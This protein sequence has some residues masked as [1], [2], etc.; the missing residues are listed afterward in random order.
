MKKPA[1]IIFLIIVNFLLYLSLNGQSFNI[2]NYTNTSSTTGFL[3]CDSLLL[4]STEGG[5]LKYNLNNDELIVQYTTSEGISDVFCTSIAGEYD[6]LWITTN[7]GITRETPGVA[8]IYTIKDGIGSKEVKRVIKAS[9][10]TIWAA[11]VNGVSRFSSGQWTNYTMQDGLTDNYARDITEHPDGSIW[12]ATD[13]GGISIYREGSWQPYSLND[14]LPIS[15]VY[16]IAVDTSGTV[17]AGTRLGLSRVNDS[18]VTNY[19]T[20][21]GLLDDWITSLSVDTN[22]NIW[23]GTWYGLSMYNHTIFKN[24]DIDHVAKN[25]KITSLYSDNQGIM[26]VGT[27]NGFL[28]YQDS[29][30]QYHRVFHQIPSNKVEEIAHQDKYVWAATRKG[31]AGFSNNKWS[32]Y[33]FSLSG[34]TGFKSVHT[35]K[36]N[37]VWFGCDY[38]YESDT[39]ILAFDGVSW[40]M[41]TWSSSNAVWDIESGSNGK[42]WFGTS[43]LIYYYTGFSLIY[44]FDFTNAPVKDIE[45]DSHGRMWMAND[46]LDLYSNHSLTNYRIYDGLPSDDVNAIAVNHHDNIWC[47]TNNGLSYFDRFTFQNFS[48]EDGL[49]H[50]SIND[51][52]IDAKGNIWMATQGGISIYTGLQWFSITKTDGLVDENCRDIHFE[53]DT[54]AWISTYGGISRIYFDLPESTFKAIDPGYPVSRDEYPRVF[55]NPAHDFI[56]IQSND[57]IKKINIYNSNGNLILTKVLDNEFFYRLNIQGISDGVYFMELFN[58]DNR[59][60]RKIIISR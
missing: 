41:Y 12:V 45:F 56:N 16:S 4:I 17:W 28:S 9:D 38:D 2:T 58:Q 30:W 7:D 27:K 57:E 14:S 37:T 1:K 5:I 42:L 39:G 8:F 50:S 48:M 52:E 46:G 6:D 21:D 43:N 35:D 18:S 36:N 29:T 59:R 22:N 3:R 20:D 51:V 54:C 11:T 53:N 47:G 33:E 49:L 10:G 40:K 25:T 60:M 13:D 34:N 44:F 24:H 23:C 31:I 32:E 55:P 19:T 15:W 26:W